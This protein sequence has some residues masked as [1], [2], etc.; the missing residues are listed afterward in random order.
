MA[1]CDKSLP[2]MMMA[3]ASFHD[4]P[5]I[6]VPGGVTLAAIDGEDAGKAQSLG[7]RY[8]HGEV[9]LEEASR[10]LCNTCATPGGEAV[11]S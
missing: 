5:S 9:T 10:K 11:N 1:T 2:A 4:L 3:L 6:L 8:T 7:I